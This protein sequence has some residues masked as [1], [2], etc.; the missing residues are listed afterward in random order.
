[1]TNTRVYCTFQFEAFHMWP[2]A[3][4]QVNYLRTPHRHVFHVR[5]E[6]DV[7][8]NDR[9][10]EF[11]TLKQDLLRAVRTK[12]VDAKHVVATWSCEQWAQWMLDTFS[13]RQVEVSED[14]ENGAVVS[15]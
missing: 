7:E 10:V 14:G 11:I 9:D 1:M 6:T 5:A 3:P 13:L 15:R 2:A 8:H 4:E 12:I